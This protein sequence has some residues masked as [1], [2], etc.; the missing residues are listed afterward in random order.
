ML[1]SRRSEKKKMISMGFVFKRLEIGST[2]TNVTVTINLL[3]LYS[4]SNEAWV[5][6]KELNTRIGDISVSVGLRTGQARPG[7]D[8]PEPGL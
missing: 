8:R 1:A 4:K 5:L 6:I 2:W 3:L 7:F